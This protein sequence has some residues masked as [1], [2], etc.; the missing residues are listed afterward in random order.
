MRSWILSPVSGKTAILLKKLKQ[1]VTG[2]II[3]YNRKFGKKSKKKKT[4]KQLAG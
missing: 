1:V 2:F 3:W 4:I